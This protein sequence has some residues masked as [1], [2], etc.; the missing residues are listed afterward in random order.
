MEGGSTVRGTGRPRSA[1]AGRN[2]AS[3][4]SPVLQRNLSRRPQSALAA[5]TVCAIAGDEVPPTETCAA[6]VDALQQE[7]V[8]T[9]SVYLSRGLRQKTPPLA[10]YG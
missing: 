9:R 1:A 8:V 10:G 6:S 4:E 5:V 3:A 2:R 7:R